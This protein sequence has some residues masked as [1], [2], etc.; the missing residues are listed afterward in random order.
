MVKT[1]R[2]SIDGKM[3]TFERASPIFDT[4]YNAEKTKRNIQNRGYYT[5]LL[6]TSKGYELYVCRY[7]KRK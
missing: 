5:R 4:K 3:Q 2:F 1:K 6:K 7:R